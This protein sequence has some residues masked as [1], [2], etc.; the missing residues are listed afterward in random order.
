MGPNHVDDWEQDLRTLT[1]DLYKVELP[2]KLPKGFLVQ[3]YKDEGINLK[4]L[5]KTRDDYG[6]AIRRVEGI[7][8]KCMN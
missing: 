7:P 2:K 3:L 1:K 5:P 6:L 4:P 8:P